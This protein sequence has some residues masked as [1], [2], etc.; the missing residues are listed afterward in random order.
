LYTPVTKRPR[1]TQVCRADDDDDGDD[2]TSVTLLERREV[3]ECAKKIMRPVK[4]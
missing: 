1:T 3:S 2:D 4:G